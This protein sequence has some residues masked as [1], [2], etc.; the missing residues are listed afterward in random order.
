MNRSRHLLAAALLASA[1]SSTPSQ[2]A[3]ELHPPILLTNAINRS[4]DDLSGTWTYSKDRYRV[5]LS[6]MNNTPPDPR[7]QRYRDVIVQAEEKA[8]PSI[9]FE[10]DM[11]RAP[12]ATLPGSWNM[13]NTELRY[14]DG[15]MWYQ[16]TFNARDLGKDSSTQRA[17]LRFEA[18]NYKASVYLNGK[19]VGQHEGGFTP[20]TFEV[21]SLLRKG[22]NQITV[23]VD[24]TRNDESVPPTFTDW[25]L[26]GGITR[27]VRLIYTPKTYIDDQH[28][29]LNED[30]SISASVKLDGPGAARQPVTLS[31]AE[32]GLKL[33][34][35]TDAA[36]Q[37]TFKVKAP[38]SLQRWSPES[39]KLYDVQVQAG[40]DSLSDRV[41]FRTIKVVGENILLNG[42]P[43][44]LRGISM[45]E[46]EF[47]PTPARIITPQAARALLSEIK[48]GLNGNYVRLSHYPHSELTVRMADEMG[49]L[50][51][52]E[53][54]V[55]W[56]VD[57]SSAK[58]LLTARKMMA[59]NIL[60]DRN[61][62]SV[63]VWSVGNETPGTPE[64][65]HFQ[66]TLAD[67]TRALDPSRLVSAALWADKAK[68]GKRIEAKITDPLAAKLDILAI[69]TYTGWYGD[70]S[71]ADITTMNWS[72]LH[73]KPMVLSEFGADAKANYHDPV[74]QPKYSEEFQ[75][76]FYTN[77]LKMADNISFLRG[78][79]PWILKDFQSPRREHPVYQ[80]GWNRKGV[81]SET[82]E[83][84]L[85]FDV[86]SNYFKRKAEAVKP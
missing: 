70:D 61:R 62:A 31:I 83:R 5:S 82:G 2:A 74:N 24:S 86:L 67:D 75:A 64:R 9:F 72:N 54:P 19:F 73:G 18:V 65:L 20:F 6:E 49:L 37:A 34:A 68:V 85:A 27:P 58:A 26:Y 28:L 11:Q 17:F 57:F 1:L 53:I 45:H 42:R 23:G 41:G 3:K 4:G 81:I 43:I 56:S 77:T 15:L 71:L 30:G 7:N 52:S 33:T 63:F 80:N 66:S 39:P 14:Y 29:N 46:E 84:K 50:V 10:Y 51:W 12:R 25:E 36:G 78:V 60:R 13:P 35:S 38:A 76:Q 47:G 59:E 22:E 69:N 32:L 55:Y 48:Y 21:T 44:F 16:R 40:D 8:N 79:S